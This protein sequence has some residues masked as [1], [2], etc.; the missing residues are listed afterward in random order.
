MSTLAVFVMTTICGI[1]WGGFTLLILRAL[2]REAV[3]SK[4]NVTNGP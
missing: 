1:V 4:G 3:K 2:R